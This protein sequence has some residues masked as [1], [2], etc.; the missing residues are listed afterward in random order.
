MQM[1]LNGK[2][3]RPGRTRTR[4]A[5]AWLNGVLAACLLLGGVTVSAQ[6]PAEDYT[7]VTEAI[8]VDPPPGDWPMWRRTYNHWGHSPLDQIDATNVGSLRLAWAWTMA[9]GKQETTPLVHDGIMFLVQACDFVEALDV[10]DGSRLWQYRRTQVE[11]AASMACANRNGALWEDKLII[12]T[13]DAHLVA[14]NVRTGEVEWD[15][16]VGDWTVGHHYSGGPQVIKG[17]VVAG[18]SGCYQLNTRCWVSAHDVETGAEVWRTYTIPGPGEFGYDTWGGI[19]DNERRGGS[20]WNAPSYDPELNLIYIGVGVPI[21][22]GSVQRG[23]G[24]GDVLFTNSTLALNADT[25]EIVWYFQHIPNDEWD[26]DH[27]FARMI[28]ETVVAPRADAVQWMNTSVTP[29]EP[30]KIVTGIPGKTGIVWALDAATGDFLWA[31]PTN[32]Q[33]VVIDIDAESRRV[34]LNPELKL[35]SVGEPV[36][37]C[38]SL[39]GGINWQATAYHPGTN[40]LYAPTNNT[41]NELTLNEFRLRPG[42]HHGSAR[43]ALSEVPDGDGQ[44]GQFTAVDLSTGETL[45]VHRQRAGFGGSVLTT[46]GGLVF[47]TDDAR[48]FRAFDAQTGEVHWEQIL[49]SS[50]GGYPV[51]YMHDGVQ[52]VAIAA[53]GGVNFRGLTPEIRQP[54]RGNMLFVFRLP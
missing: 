40:A 6:S 5:S 53:G 51:S 13:H 29:G 23:T 11:H 26:L 31:R 35:P 16:P 39:T 24:D 15:E 42:A 1:C 8:L 44:I 7:P 49:N 9:E 41:C 22:W 50:A 54:G 4:I 10:R 33:N 25:G 19:P 30:R 46:G 36:F 37:V 28:V 20:A 21:P 27:P 32:F 18:M 3:E 43:V 17:Q 38:P 47:V 45:W 14:L 2:D 34:L 52:Y 48:R 12:G